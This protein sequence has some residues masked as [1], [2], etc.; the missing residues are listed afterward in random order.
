MV[1]A[2]ILNVTNFRLTKTDNKLRRNMLN[3]YHPSFRCGKGIQAILELLDVKFLFYV[4][5]LKKKLFIVLRRKYL[6]SI[7]FL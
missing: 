5:D 3:S 7:K 1:K 2:E 6:K 4:E